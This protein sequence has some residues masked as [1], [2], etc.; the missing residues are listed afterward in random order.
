[1]GGVALELHHARG[2]TDDHTWTWLAAARVLC[3]GDLFIWA[4]PNAGNPQK[5]QRYPRE[6]A[7]A[8]RE[9]IAL[10]PEV[11]LPGHGFPVI[12]A[13]RVRQALTDTAEL[14]DSLVDQTIELMN[15]GARLD[16]VLHT[17]I[18]P[19]HL[20]DRPYLRP[21]YDEPEFVVR[22]VWRLY[23]G[24]WDGNPA[25]LKPAPE[26]ALAGRAGRPGRRGRCPGRPG[27]G[28]APVAARGQRPGRVDAAGG[29][30]GRAGG[31]GRALRRRR[32]P[33][34][35][36]GVRPPV[37]KGHLDHGERGLH[38]DRPGVREP[39][40]TAR[41]RRRAPTTT[42]GSR[43]ASVV[44]VSRRDAETSRTFASRKRRR[45]LGVLVAAALPIVLGGCQLP[46]FYGYRGSTKQGHDEFL[47]YAGTV[48]AAIVV[49]VIVAALI[50]W[51]VV[52]YRK[53]SDE[54][55]RQFQYHI[56][57]EIT[58]IVV[59]VIM[60]LILFGFTV[61]TENQVDAVSP[62]PALKVHVTAFQWG[63]SYKYP[64]NVTVT[65]V[66]TEDPDPVGLN[67]AQCA[68]AVDCLGPGLVVPA[69]E[70][71][72]ITLNSN[73][74]IHGFYV[75]QFNFSRYAQPGVTNVFDLT[76]QHAGIYR[77]QCTQ[78]CGLYHSLMFFHVVALPPS[79]FRA[80]LSSQQ[81]AAATVSASISHPTTKA[82]A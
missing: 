53:R 42:R 44:A 39:G 23:G 30:P 16:E 18:A 36:R 57:L 68:P 33:G 75:P 82:A 78:L 25:S 59:P 5:V 70:T 66:T 13:A 81:S 55:P 37:G 20:V 14:L 15:A 52:R 56:P 19:A 60:V 77:A 12:G 27:P 49:G 43:L 67:G 32:P 71:T 79:Q 74:V 45:A 9:M 6:W 17:V 21:V 11:L 4:S 1:M 38:L 46:T 26:A 34:A 24:W 40:P 35:R 2:E 10:E 76:V 64:G 62:T 65:G 28:T 47:L 73:D 58:Y 3:C 72:R 22:N 51:S 61:F 54:M 41:L 29:P 69:G 63:W 48:I 80:W 8:L 31:A 50:V 7:A